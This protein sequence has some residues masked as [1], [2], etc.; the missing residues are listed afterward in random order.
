[1]PA[2]QATYSMPAAAGH[3][4]QFQSRNYEHF[5]VTPNSGALGADVEGIDL[6]QA[7]DTAFAEIEQALADHLV[8][9]IRGQD[10]EPKAQIAFAERLGPL[11]QYRYVE[12]MPGY[13]H[14][15][16]LL[17]EPG[18]VYNFGG[19]W[20]SDTPQIERPPMYTMLYAVECPPVGGDTSYANQYMAWDTLSAD[21]RRMLDTL[22]TVHSAALSFGGHYGSE[23]VQGKSTTQSAYA[24]DL[25]IET[26]HPVGRTHPVTG[27]KALYVCSSY[28]AHF[29]GM[30]QEE[31]LP[32]LRYLWAHSI[33]PDFTCR[34]RWRPGTL[35]IWDN[36]SCLHYAHN[37]YPGQR[38][39]MRRIVIEGERPY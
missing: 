15:S 26:A 38:R 16:E 21:M 31:S 17:T 4:P 7:G 23:E 18:D 12:P 9:F 19:T 14:L 24:A 36:R 13:P 3:P 37:D 11:M 10:L 34:F 1:M 35:A 5:R 28:A 22:H 8:L 33:Q 25:K 6:R 2:Y 27:R 29:V 20:H 30:S 39:L 32:L